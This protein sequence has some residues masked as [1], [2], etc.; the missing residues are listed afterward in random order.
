MYSISGRFHVLLYYWHHPHHPQNH[1]FCKHKLLYGNSDPSSSRSSTCSAQCFS[2]PRVNKSSFPD[3]RAGKLFTSS[4]CLDD[5][6]PLRAPAAAATRACARERAWQLIT[7]R[8]CERSQNWCWLVHVLETQY[9]QVI[10][11]KT[12]GVVL[13]GCQGSGRWWRQ[14]R[15]YFFFLFSTRSLRLV[16]KQTSRNKPESVV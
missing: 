2:P 1:F 12:V 7:R 8:C 15:F 16:S 11:W 3:M 5:A 6:S 10:G 13:I 4:T 14:W 9:K